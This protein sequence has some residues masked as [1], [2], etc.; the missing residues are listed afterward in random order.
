MPRTETGQPGEE[1]KHQR[2]VAKRDGVSIQV[3]LRFCS[4]AELDVGLSLGSGLGLR[5]SVGRVVRLSIGR[6]VLILHEAL[7][8]CITDTF[9]GEV[10]LPTLV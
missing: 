9:Q 10:L 6:P 3:R 2:G 7:C 1:M 4:G 8:C 5:S